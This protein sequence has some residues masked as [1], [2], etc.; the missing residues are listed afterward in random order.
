M[1]ASIQ[2]ESNFELNQVEIL[3]KEELGVAQNYKYLSEKCAMS[4]EQALAA[5]FGETPG[6]KRQDLFHSCNR[7]KKLDLTLVLD[8]YSVIY[9]SVSASSV[10]Y[11]S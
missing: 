11:F 5:A 9:A 2:P 7:Y 10:M 3:V 8:G 4:K 1:T 6:Y